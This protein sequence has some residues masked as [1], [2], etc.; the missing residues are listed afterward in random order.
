MTRSPRLTRRRAR[1]LFVLPLASLLTVLGAGTASA[2]PLGNFTVNHYDGLTLGV[3]R[4]TN[5]AVV[6]TAEIPT[7]Q[8]R[9]LVDADHDGTISD[10]ERSRHASARCAALV[11]GLDARLGEQVLRWTVS[12]A[13]F[14]YRD[15]VAGLQVS[16]LECTMSTP[17]RLAEPGTLSFKDN[18]LGDRLGWREITATGDGVRLID[19]PVPNRSVS[20]EL[21]SYPDDLL[22]SPLDVRSAEL[23]VRPGGGVSTFSDAADL[24]VAGPIARA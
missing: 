4:V 21:R 22:S 9:T 12:A 15:G 19:S 16:R 17:A 23:Q 5:F 24:P 20:A 18:F 13:S 14:S 7:L 10:A 3:D 1:L 2:H 11:A 6:D 8:E